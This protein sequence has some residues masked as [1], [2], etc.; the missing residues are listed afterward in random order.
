V[1]ITPENLERAACLFAVEH[2]VQDTWQN[3]NDQFLIPDKELTEEFKLD[4]LIYMLFHGKNLTASADGLEWN[5][6]KWSIVNHFIPFTEEEVNAP[7]R[8]ESDFMV[9]YLKCRVLSKELAEASM[10]LC[11]LCDLCG[12]KESIAVLVSGREIW[13]EYFRRFS[14]FDYSIREKFKLNRPDV[15]WYQ[16]RQALKAYGESAE[17][18]PT[19]FSKFESAYRALA[20]KL[21]PKVYEYGFLK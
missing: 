18:R 10:N 11:D 15:G 1:Y 2:L 3:H 12:S 13:R 14:S 19:D 17:G 6:R 21:R 9:R 16:I 7:D 20:D 5:G 4:C 8:F